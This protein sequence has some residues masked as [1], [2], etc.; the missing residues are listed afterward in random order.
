MA[1]TKAVNTKKVVIPKVVMRQ[2]HREEDDV[3]AIQQNDIEVKCMSDF[4]SN[5]NKSTMSDEDKI[6][7]I[8]VFSWMVGVE[9]VLRNA[10]TLEVMSRGEAEDGDLGNITE[11]S[12][13]ARALRDMKKL[14]DRFMDQ[15]LW[16][17]ED[18][19]DECLVKI[20]NFMIHVR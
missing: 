13:P 2:V 17:L 20:D 12:K 16:E 7:S 3:L 10:I 8:D 9:L 18:D 11:D 14:A 4:E 5:V 15:K 1:K 19:D 6:K